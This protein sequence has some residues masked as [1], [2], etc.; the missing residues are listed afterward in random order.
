MPLR[1]TK[2]RTKWLIRQCM[3]SHSP[4]KKSKLDGNEPDERADSGDEE[5]DEDKQEDKPVV[6][7]GIFSNG[8]SDKD[9]VPSG[10]NSESLKRL[11]NA[12][13]KCILYISLSLSS[14]CHIQTQTHRDTGT[15]TH[16]H[17]VEGNLSK[18]E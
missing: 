13:F 11:F 2:S 7:D 15:H 9:V 12:A 4:Q 14:L 1:L 3:P 6:I 16:T 18:Q 8:R 5:S 10:D 17:T